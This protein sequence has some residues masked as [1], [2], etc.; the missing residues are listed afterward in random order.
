MCSSATI[1]SCV[2]FYWDQRPG[3]LANGRILDAFWTFDRKTAVYL[4]IHARESRDNGRTWSEMW[5]AGIPGQPAPPV[6][7]PDGRIALVYMDRTK[8]PALKLRLSSDGG[9][10]WPKETEMVL[11]E[12]K[13]PTQTWDK[14]SMQD[15]W[16]EM[17]KFSVGLPATATTRNGDVLIVYYAGTHT[18]QTGI[19]WVRVCP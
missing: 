11:Y 7:L 10:S 8:A 9:R 19:E 18:N 4:N 16:S 6:S 2:F 3:V 17:G 12:A 14:K 15:A 13:L 5:D 1:R